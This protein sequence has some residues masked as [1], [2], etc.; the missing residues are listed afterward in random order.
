VA[1]EDRSP[2]PEPCHCPYTN[3]AVVGGFA[4][5]AGDLTVKKEACSP[6]RMHAV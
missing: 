1:P 5:A 4:V 3:F 2:R 6:G